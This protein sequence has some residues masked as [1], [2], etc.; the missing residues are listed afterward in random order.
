MASK[1]SERIAEDSIPS[2]RWGESQAS[3]AYFTELLSRVMDEGFLKELH[4][5]GSEV[6]ERRPEDI[7]ALEKI[8]PWPRLI[9]VLDGEQRYALSR[10][11]RRFD[12]SLS[13]GDAVFWTRHAWQL[14]FWDEPC[15]FFGIVFRDRA[16]RFLHVEHQPGGT[17]KPPKFFHHT[18]GPLA[19]PGAPLL[20]AMQAL[21]APRACQAAAPHVFKALLELSL[22]HLSSSQGE[23]SH[24]E[25]K[26]LRTWR[27]VLDYLR[28]NFAS[29]INRKTVAEA[30]GLHPNYLSSLATRQTGKPFQAAIEG[31][32]MEEARRLLGQGDLKIDRIARICG[33]GSSSY[34][35]TAFRRANG[36]SP[37]RFRGLHDDV[38]D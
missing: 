26:A 14:E 1:M 34:F 16:L 37:A 13:P 11:S 23:A 9:V 29:P 17:P 25:S 36:V 2:A 21:C 6:C 8:L 35:V 3:P 12:A 32:R 22:E 27:K 15:S 10:D 33:Y 5:C 31:F 18:P 30:L 19:G 7:G 4:L 24:E 38:G 20:D 28:E